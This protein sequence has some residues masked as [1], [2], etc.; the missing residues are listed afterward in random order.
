MQH[1]IEHALIATPIGVL[2]A[3]VVRLVAGK[4]GATWPALAGVGWVGGSFYY[5]GREVRD[6]EKG[7]VAAIGFDYSGLLVPMG[8]LALVFGGAACCLARRDTQ[9]SGGQ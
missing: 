7:T 2:A 4:A 3:L 5:A 6:W 9:R 8:W 1:Y